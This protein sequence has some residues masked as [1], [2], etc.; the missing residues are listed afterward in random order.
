MVAESRDWTIAPG[1][2]LAELLDERGISQA[3]LARRMGR[4]TKTM[5]EI[6]NGKAAITAQTALQLERVLGVGARFW[7]N[8]EAAYRHDLARFEEQRAAEE[9]A[10]WLRSFPVKD[11]V[12]Q[13]LISANATGA[14]VLELLSFF[15]VGSPQAWETKWANPAV[16]FRESKARP[17]SSHARSAWLRWGERLGMAADL[18]PFDEQRLRT[19]VSE[20]PR[21]SRVSPPEAAVEELAGALALAGVAF[22]VTPEFAGTR[23]SGAAHWPTPDRPVVQ[24]SGR[25][26]TD[27]HFWFTVLHETWHLLASPGHDFADADPDDP[28]A[29]QN[30]T[31]AR[32]DAAARETLIPGAALA[33]FLAS[34]RP[35][36]RAAVRAFAAELGISP[37]VVVGRLQ[38]DRHLGYG[39]LNDLKRPFDVR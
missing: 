21:L 15:G 31:E 1:E 16:V 20:L 10:P 26:G 36:D 13:G 2:F 12:A 3:E 38:H 28:A 39:D 17:A 35:D 32:V 18:P 33:R 4:P 8:A 37:G 24:L 7:L 9:A 30:E 22:V 23:L 19:V 25:H 29:I 14:Q 5:N 27:D 34:A 11:L 6:V